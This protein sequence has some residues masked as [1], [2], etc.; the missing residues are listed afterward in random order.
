LWSRYNFIP[1][2]VL[3]VGAGIFGF[4]TTGP[5]ISVYQEAS[6]GAFVVIFSIGGL[7]TGSGS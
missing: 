7:F 2:V 1:G 3:I 6:S 4:V 5:S